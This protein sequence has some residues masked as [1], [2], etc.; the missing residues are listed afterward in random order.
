MVLP[1][2]ALLAS[3]LASARTLRPAAV[4]A[5]P[6]FA[7]AP[8][9]SLAAR[10]SPVLIAPGDGPTPLQ[11]SSEDGHI[12]VPSGPRGRELAPLSSFEPPLEPVD[13]RT[14]PRK[15]RGSEKVAAEPAPAPDAPVD[16]GTKANGPVDATRAT[17]PTR[18]DGASAL[19]ERVG[20][21]A[22]SLV[23]R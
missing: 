8:V 3:G 6:R 10:L 1:C 18:D 7:A 9:A 5:A 19:L 4:A 13:W 21:L 15:G 20:A 12:L 14:G 2:I 11:E 23:D 17:T 22:K 16:G